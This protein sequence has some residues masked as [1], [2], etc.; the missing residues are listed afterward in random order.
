[1]IYVDNSLA[2]ILK[3]LMRLDQRNVLVVAMPHLLLEKFAHRKGM[4]SDKMKPCKQE[5]FVEMS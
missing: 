2:R 3:S 4:G 5:C 1:M